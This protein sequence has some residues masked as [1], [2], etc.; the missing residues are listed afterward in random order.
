LDLW[1]FGCMFASMVRKGLICI[2]MYMTKIYT[3]IDIP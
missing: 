3:Y 2:Y 1:S